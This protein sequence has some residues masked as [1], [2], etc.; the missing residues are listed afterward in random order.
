MIHNMAY[1][2]IQ[3]AVKL[4]LILRRHNWILKILSF[5]YD[6]CNMWTTPDIYSEYFNIAQKLIVDI[7]NL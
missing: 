1:V 6:I 4:N 5:V 3:S 2:N 7:N